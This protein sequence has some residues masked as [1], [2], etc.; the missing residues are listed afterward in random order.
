MPEP[1]GAMMDGG[2]HEEA[3]RYTGPDYARQNPT[4]DVEDSAWKA[5]HVLRVLRRN[6][7]WPST[8]ADIGCGAGEVLSKLADELPQTDRL[9]GFEISP[10][11]HALCDARRSDR[12]SFRLGSVTDGDGI[13]DIMLLM[14]VVEHVENP[15]ALLR[16][17]RGRSRYVILHIPL[18]LSAQ[19][20]LRESP[21]LEV[22]RKVGHLHFYTKELALRTLT[23]VGYSIV[24]WFYTAG[25]LDL[26]AKSVRSRIAR[27]PRRLL[28]TLGQDLA[29]R[30]VGGFS[31][32]VLAEHAQRPGSGNAS[33]SVARG[34]VV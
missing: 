29:A 34:K 10:N 7:L 32:M 1:R 13:F 33:G 6:Q 30:A 21:L 11:A 9:V 2:C 27:L 24:D 19:S 5:G 26:P 22:R 28:F 18:D 16:N 15:F 31:L 12:V 20:V 8:I 23:D 3:A 17:L 25:S 14:D 4:W